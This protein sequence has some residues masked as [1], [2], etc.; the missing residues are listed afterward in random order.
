M[1][2][3]SLNDHEFLTDSTGNRRFWTIECA[4]ADIDAVTAYR[5]Q[6]WAEAYALYEQ[7]QPWWLETDE[8][9]ALAEAEQAKHYEA[10]P[11]DELI[12]EWIQTPKQ[13]E[14]V[15][16]FA[17]ELPWNGSR[18]GRVNI[19]DVLVHGLQITVDKIKPADSH[20]VGRCL[21]HLGWKVSQ[22]SAGTHRGK[23]YYVSPQPPGVPWSSR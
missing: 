7:D 14:R 21:R 3:A 2:C 8:L 5:D 23:R 6:L 16:A 1:F 15:N 19:Q 13:R 10:G 12:T 22:E 18:P 20:E 11:R 4:K 9:T 17:D